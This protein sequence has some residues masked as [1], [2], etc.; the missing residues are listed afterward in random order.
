MVLKVDG[1]V[2]RRMPGQAPILDGID[3]ALGAGK[4]LCLLGPNG[5]GKT[6]LLRCLI[7]ALHAERGSVRIEGE[8][9]I[10]A[11]RLASLMA[12]VPQAAGDSALTLLDTVLM[13]RT[14]H[15]PPLALPGRHDEQLAMAALTRVGIAHLAARPFNRVSGGERQLA[16]IARALA[17]QPRLFMMDEPTASLD[18]GNQVRVLRTIRDLAADGMTVLVTTHQPEHALLL[19]AHVAAIAGGRI[20]ATGHAHDVLQPKMLAELYG[21]PVDVVSH[22]GVPVACVPQ[23]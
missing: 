10:P 11:R 7:G 14:P 9:N 16:L 18:L 2:Y 20:A 8:V 21:T 13:G 5:S 23:L 1:L 22:R 12:Y 3:L 19:G 6:T 17:Q 4:I 15:L